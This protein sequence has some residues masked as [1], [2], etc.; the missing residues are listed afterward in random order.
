[1]DFSESLFLSPQELKSAID[2]KSIY[3]GSEF[4]TNRGKRF[5]FT[6]GTQ[7]F[8]FQVYGSVGVISGQNADRPTCK[9]EDY[10][11]R[12]NNIHPNSVVTVCKFDYII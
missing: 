11:D 3:L 8:K 6:A 9:G 10:R 7:T 5:S 2:D 1:M 4:E 12:H